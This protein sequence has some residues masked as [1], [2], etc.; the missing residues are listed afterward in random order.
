MIQFESVQP[1]HSMSIRQLRDA[2]MYLAKQVLTHLAADD[3]WTVLSELAVYH[4]AVHA[5]VFTLACEHVGID[6]TQLGTFAFVLL[7]SGARG[8]QSIASDQDHALVYVTEERIAEQA[9]ARFERIGQVTAALL[10]EVGYPLCTGNVMA[11]NP[12]WRG[13]VADWTTRLREYDAF[14][15][16]DRIRFLLIAADACPIVGEPA[17]SQDIRGQAVAYIAKSPF[18][19][20]K[21]ADQ[22]LSQRVPLTLLGG[23][24]TDPTGDWKGTFHIKDGVY[25]PLVNSIRLWALSVGIEEPG[26]R[27]RI[28]GLLR[29]K[30]WDQ[31]LANEVLEALTCTLRLRVGHHAEQAAAMLPI[32]DHIDPQSLSDRDREL[33]KRAL[34]TTRQ[35]QQ[36]TARRFPKGG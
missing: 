12:R 13:S 34:R 31:T 28:A 23:I 30:T 21:V 8:E 10:H 36:L 3:I 33:V 26:S 11:S 19:R 18:M 7:G 35:L 29:A 27:E 24:R 14:P 16:W 17:L 32:H 22:G 9:Q 25:T 1:L 5:R 4:R 15:D 6:M 2:Q 20:W